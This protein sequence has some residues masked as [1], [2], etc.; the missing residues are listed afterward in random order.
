MDIES[1]PRLAAIREAQAKLR[2][3]CDALDE[4]RREIEFLENVIFLN[5]RWK[6]KVAL[7][8]LLHTMGILLE[9]LFCP[10]MEIS[11]NFGGVRNV[12]CSNTRTN[13]ALSKQSEV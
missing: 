8:Q 4:R 3:E 2:Q 13:L 11:N 10:L 5:R 1:S 6:R 7:H 9:T 12:K